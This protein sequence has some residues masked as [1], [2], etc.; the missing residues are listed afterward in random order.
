[1]FGEFNETT[2]L[3]TALAKYLIEFNGLLYKCVR[4]EWR[5]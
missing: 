3:K 5:I 1:M 2:Q 4:I